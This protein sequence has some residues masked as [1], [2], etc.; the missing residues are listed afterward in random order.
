MTRASSIRHA[1][2]WGSIGVSTGV[3]IYARMAT[4]PWL[5]AIRLILV[6]VGNRPCDEGAPQ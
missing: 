4:F 6:Q 1:A 5:P 3:T 2:D